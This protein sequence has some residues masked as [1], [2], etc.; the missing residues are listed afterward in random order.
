MDL[1]DA[2]GTIVYMAFN[3]F[4]I[5]I[6]EKTWPIGHFTVV[7]SL[8]WPLIGSEAGGDVVLIQTSLLLFCKLK[9][10][11]CQLVCIYMLKQRAQCKVTSSLATFKGQVT[12]QTTVK[13]PIYFRAGDQNN[14]SYHTTVTHR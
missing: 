7:C 13:W 8:T 11:C 6:N 14:I 10:F 9:L 4:I 2:E 5:A 3:K 12:K 1:I